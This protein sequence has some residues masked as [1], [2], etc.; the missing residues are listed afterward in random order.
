VLLT[1]LA[2]A[3]LFDPG[4]CFQLFFKGPKV[5]FGVLG[6]LVKSVLTTLRIFSVLC[7]Y[8]TK[9]TWLWAEFSRLLL[10]WMSWCKN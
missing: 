3:G 7:I 4:K 8:L 9:N 1:F 10:S 2:D 5:L 6:N